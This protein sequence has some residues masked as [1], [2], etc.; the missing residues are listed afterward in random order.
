MRSDCDVKRID[1][2]IGG[3]DG[4][5]H[6]FVRNDSDRRVKR[7]QRNPLKRLKPICGKRGI[8]VCCFVK[9][10]LRYREVIF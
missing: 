1:N 2:R 3:Q 6:D 7:K 8:A 9:H 10:V 5:S 4:S